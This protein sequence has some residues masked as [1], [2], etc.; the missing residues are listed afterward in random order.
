MT[1]S[2]ALPDDFDM[3]AALH[4]PYGDVLGPSRRPT[5][6]GFDFTPPL[7]RMPL[8]TTRNA[9]SLIFR[10]LGA[11]SDQQLSTPSKAPVRTGPQ[12]EQPSDVNA[13][14]NGHAAYP[15][16]VHFR[17]HSLPAFLEQPA[18]DHGYD[19]YDLPSGKLPA[20]KITGL[21][22]APMTMA[23]SRPDD[24]KIDNTKF[25]VERGNDLVLE[26]VAH[27][28]MKRKREDS[29]NDIVTELLARWTNS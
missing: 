28:P 14:P 16:A 2:R 19:Q 12:V 18:F 22:S 8:H 21:G 7:S 27:A 4:A 3:K 13:N 5:F 29:P 25:E 17:S 24:P 1:R 26:H 11:P 15:R 9:E 6:G 23:T 20:E 10:P